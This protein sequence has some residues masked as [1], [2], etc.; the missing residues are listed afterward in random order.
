MVVDLSWTSNENKICF[1]DLNICFSS[2]VSIY[3]DRTGT[4]TR[5]PHFIALLLIETFLAVENN[6]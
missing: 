3:F 4:K 6:T 1:M 5:T 2:F